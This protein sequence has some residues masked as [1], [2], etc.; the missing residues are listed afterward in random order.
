MACF[1]IGSTG[2]VGAGGSLVPHARHGAFP[3][4]PD[5]MTRTWRFAF[6]AAA[7]CLAATAH[8][9]ERAAAAKPDLAK[10]QQIVTQICA[11]CHGA[12][13]NSVAAANPNLA[14]QDAD[15]ITLQLAH[16]KAGIRVNPT[17]QAM[18]ATLGDEDMRALGAYYGAQ[19]PKGLA[20]KDASLVKAAQQLWRG[21]DAARG[22]PA[23]AAC[24]SPTGAGIPKNYPR[25]AG[26][27]A[28]YT[29]AQLKAF[30]AGERGADEAGKDIN[31]RVMHTIA[32]Q[33]T[34]AQMKAVADYA[35][36]LR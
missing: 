4:S 6:L 13:G 30:K 21:G 23:C 18:A 8:G 36:G 5:D 22:V 20:A 25:L 33:M 26:Q 34:D 11:A 7:L 2:F 29:Y 35:A 15:Y 32:Q 19:K 27:Y 14:G 16:F 12:D 28:D 10:A 1:F 17:M 3:W 24:H 9:Q 31:G